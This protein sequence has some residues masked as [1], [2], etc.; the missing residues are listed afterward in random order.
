MAKLH[1]TSEKRNGSTELQ[2]APKRQ[3]LKPEIEVKREYSS[4]SE[5]EK[6]EKIVGSLE[7]SGNL[8]K[9]TN[10]VNG[11]IIKYNEPPEARKP[12]IRWKLYPFKGEESLD[13]IPVHRQSAYLLGRDRRVADIPTDHPSCSK[14]H[15]VLQFRVVESRESDSNKT[16]SS[17][18]AL[19]VAEATDQKS[20]VV[21]PTSLTLIQQ[22][23][24]FSTRRGSTVSV[25]WSYFLAMYLNLGF[26]LENMY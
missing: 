3:E 23:G 21:K 6:V 12:T 15:A 5:E 8:L 1:S 26:P 9:D 19:G 25:L 17:L 7:L 14:Q 16:G 20:F 4:E 13:V 11:V 24:H 10:M 2:N 22:T 18:T